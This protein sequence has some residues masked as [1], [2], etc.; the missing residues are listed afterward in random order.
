MKQKMKSVLASRAALLGGGL[1][2]AC[3]AQAGMVKDANGNV[4]FDSAA[5]CDAAV[6]A[7]G[8]RFYQPFTEHPPLKRV[9]EVDVKSL[10]LS[11]LVQAQKTAIALG[12]DAAGYAKGACDLGV[13]RSQGRD[14]VSR[15][16]IGKF[17][18]YSPD[19]SLNVYFDSQGTPVRASMQQCDNNFNRQ[20]PRPVGV[21]QPRHARSLCLP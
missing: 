16:L 11:E 8:V 3:A 19:M 7:G 17:V 14:G 13:G 18:P 20:L 2:M 6:A 5:E 12:Y 10:K 21:P 9:G 15:E 1:L 4:G